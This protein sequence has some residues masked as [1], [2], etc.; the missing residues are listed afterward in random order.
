MY[1]S[2]WVSRRERRGISRRIVGR[3]EREYTAKY[4]IPVN[5]FLAEI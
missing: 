2:A 3:S 5:P 1:T 4:Q